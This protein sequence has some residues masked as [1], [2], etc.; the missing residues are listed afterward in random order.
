M[1]SESL[2]FNN[3]REDFENIVKKYHTTKGQL[4]YTQNLLE[5]Y[6]NENYHLKKEIEQLNS[7]KSSKVVQFS[8]SEKVISI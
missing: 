8:P 4:E 3:L 2:N 1:Q 5:E 7:I 6:K